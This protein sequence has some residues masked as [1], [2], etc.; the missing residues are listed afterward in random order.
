MYPAIRFTAEEELT[1]GCDETRRNTVDSCKINP[2][3]CKAFCHLHQTRFTRV[4]L[5]FSRL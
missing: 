2:L 3:D 1:I 5:L 4:I